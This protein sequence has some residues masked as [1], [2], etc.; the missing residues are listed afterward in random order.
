MWLRAQQEGGRSALPCRSRLDRTRD[1]RPLTSACA[2]S[3]LHRSAAVSR[4]GWASCR[5]DA[6]PTPLPP[7]QSKRCGSPTPH[8]DA[9]GGAPVEPQW[10]PLGL[11][12]DE[13]DLQ[14]TL[15][16]FVPS[17]TF[18]PPARSSQ[19]DADQWRACVYERR[20]RS[21]HPSCFLRP[22]CGSEFPQYQT[23]QRRGAGCPKAY[24]PLGLKT[25][26]FRRCLRPPG[27]RHRTT[28]AG[29]AH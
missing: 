24:C 28:L 16:R 14:A 19:P 15:L 2:L 27:L 10:W 4:A 3:I 12:A 25:R 17:S 9:S 5:M 7:A 20:Q 1:A 29:D 8:D 21:A 11:S 13:L 22:S 6:P 18:Q 26:F 23:Y